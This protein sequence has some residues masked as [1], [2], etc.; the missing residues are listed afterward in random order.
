MKRFTPSSLSNGRWRKE[1]AHRTQYECRFI[2]DM[3]TI[4]IHFLHDEIDGRGS[5]NG[6]RDNKKKTK[7]QTLYFFHRTVKKKNGVN[8]ECLML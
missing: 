5:L 8:G 6:T 7:S 2:L 4:F 1:N 3:N